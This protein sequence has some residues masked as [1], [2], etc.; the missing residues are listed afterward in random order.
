MEE[1]VLS[2][3]L[4]RPAASVHGEARRRLGAERQASCIGFCPC[5]EQLPSAGH[6]GGSLGDD[7]DK[8][9]LA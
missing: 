6:G 4:L 5:T 9:R 3:C 1:E 2:K 7:D 8:E